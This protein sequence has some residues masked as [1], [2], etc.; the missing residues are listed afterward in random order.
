MKYKILTVVLVLAMVAGAIG[1]QNMK[2]EIERYHQHQEAIAKELC[3]DH[4]T[5]VFCTH[6]P[7]IKITTD[8]AIP[9]PFLTDEEGNV[10]IGENGQRLPNKEFVGATIEYFDQDT[11]NN[12]LSD[13]ASIMERALIRTRG[14]SSR[15][16][17]KSSYL[18][19]FKQEDLLTNKKVSLSGMVADS[20]WALQGPFMDKT[21]IRN[22]LCYNLAGEIMEY[23]PN[24]RFCEAFLNGEYIWVYLIT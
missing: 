3:T 1:V 19:K 13:Q 8:A 24:V 21:L 10:L 4:G 17:D 11:K 7:L 14:A 22:Y 15:S 20:E 6:L 16:F 2:I 9:D 12:H 23:A 5:D 18:I